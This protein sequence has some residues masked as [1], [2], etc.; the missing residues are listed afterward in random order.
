MRYPATGKRL[1]GV[2]IPMG[3]IRTDGGW[4]LGEYPDLVPFAKLCARLGAGLVQILPVND[5]GSQSSPYSALSAFALHPLYIRVC[6]L[7]EATKAP[8]AIKA[9]DVF[10]SLASPGERFPYGA[11]LDAKLAALRT[12]YDAGSKAIKSD[13]ELA[14][15]IAG[16]PWV[17]TYAVFKRLKSEYGERAWREWPA[18]RDPTPADIGKL[19][20]E[21]SAAD[22]QYFHAWVQMRAAGQFA[23]AASAV[24]SMGIAL[25]GDIPILM[26][27]DSADVW[28]ERSFFDL[29]KRAGA[30]PDMYSTTGQNWGFP[31]YDW[32]AMAAGGYSF[33]KARVAEADRYYSAFRIDHVLGFFRIWALGEREETGCLG[34]FVPGASVT[35]GDLTDAGFGKPRLRWLSEPH[36]PGGELRSAALSA[37]EAERAIGA[38]LDR[39]GDEDLYLFKRTI[40][41]EADITGLGLETGLAEFL[42]TRWR[43]RA[44]LAMGDGVYTP[45][46]SY[47]DS[48]AWA[49]LSDSE[50]STLGALFSAK[51][52]QAELGWEKRG[53]ELLSMLASSSSMLPCAE[54]LGAVPDCVPKVLAGLGIPGLRVP[55]WMRFWDL[56]GQPFKPLSSYSELSA[57]TPSVHDTS[58]LRGWWESEDGRDAFAAEYCPGLSPVPERL[59]PDAALAVL[60]ALAKAPSL[61]FVVQLQDAL[62]CSGALRSADADSD[63]VNVPGSVDGFNW[64]WRMGPSV[65]RLEAAETWI[66]D[67]RRAC[68]RDGEN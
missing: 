39:I 40:R 51:A 56:P 41:G 28:A 65:E 57:C 38:A 23:A 60:G 8:D 63:R 48:T 21:K 47:R 44:L 32:D 27:E 11:C 19:W 22:E 15:F 66:D 54:D 13:P 67:I 5:T 6:D 29:T 34:R 25:L 16:N 53:R 55:R 33:W 46:W 31:I 30:P 24:A 59:D 68:T 4:R 26:N 36:L 17:K 1:F 62:D 18:R 50:R 12:V 45:V 10:A 37:G 42:K 64:T 3:S 35:A 9:L 58:T 52:A 49:S 7:P 2:A 20:L 14:S 43:D 61:L